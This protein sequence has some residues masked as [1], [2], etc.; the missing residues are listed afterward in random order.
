MRRLVPLAMFAALLACNAQPPGYRSAAVPTRTSSAAFTDSP[1][2]TATTLPPPSATP[3]VPPSPTLA[4]GRYRIQSGDTLAAL[5]ARFGLD[6]AALLAR[7]PGL[8]PTQTLPPGLLVDLPGEPRPR[9]SFTQFLLPDSEVVLSPLARGFDVRAFVLG[10]PGFLAAYSEVLQEDQPARAGWEIVELYAHRYSLNPR[11]LLALLEFQSHALTL[12]AVDEF[13]RDHPLRVEAP[14]LK[15]GLSHQLGYAANQLN[16]AYYDWRAGAA[17]GF[18][19]ADGAW[20]TADPNLNAGSYALARLLGRLYRREA[21]LPA[22][23]PAGL[24]AAYRALFGEPAAYALEP[25]LPGGLTQPEL[26]LP[27]EPRKAWNF[28]SGPH[29]AFGR[30]TPRAAL[31]FAPPLNVSGCGPT[32]EWAVAVQAGEIIYAADGIVEL[33][34]GDGWEVVYLHIAARDRLPVGRSVQAGDRIGHPSCEGGEATGV[35]LHLARKYQGEWIPTDGFAPLVLSGWVSQ[36]GAQTF[37]GALVK[38]DRVVEACP[39]ASPETV[40]QLEP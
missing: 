33:A 22:A 30:G 15:P 28:T 32:D 6:P 23:G 39:C 36:A 13:T 8:S 18:E 14:D 9:A 7:N 19:L 40:I 37:E 16:W 17:P 2:P 3:T 26:Q 24:L 31:D 27:F 35:H 34:L 20:L 10:Q 4:P 38:G 29:R 12:P 5:A 21:F 25:L 11:L 1:R